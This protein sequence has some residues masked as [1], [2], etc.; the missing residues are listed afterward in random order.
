VPNDRF[1]GLSPLQAANSDLYNGLTLMG[2]ARKDL[3]EADDIVHNRN[4]E[5]NRKYEDLRMS[6]FATYQAGTQQLQE[7]NARNGLGQLTH[8]KNDLRAKGDAAAARHQDLTERYEAANKTTTETAASLMPA[9]QVYKN[10]Q[11]ALANHARVAEM[12]SKSNAEA[13]NELWNH[14]KGL[15]ETSGAYND[16]V[17]TELSAWGVQ[18]I[19]LIQQANSDRANTAAENA[20]TIANNK[21]LAEMAINGARV[22]H[23]QVQDAIAKMNSL[24]NTIKAIKGMKPAQ[25]KDPATQKLLQDAG[26]MI[27]A[28]NTSA[29]PPQK[30]TAQ[31]EPKPAQPAVANYGKNIEDGTYSNAVTP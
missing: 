12:V 21:F 29:Q 30:Q 18:Q 16:M 17:K 4:P 25:L 9:L 28:F 26:N 14:F 8:M 13:T 1:G 10:Y 23:E 19:A 15:I 3:R 20:V 24:N 31:P 6:R 7:L 5:L 2:R 22:A 27:D 11:D